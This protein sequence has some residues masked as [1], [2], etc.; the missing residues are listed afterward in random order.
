MWKKFC[1]RSSAAGEITNE[2]YTSSNGSTIRNEKTG[3]KNLLTTF[4]WAVW[5]NSGSFT[6]ETQ[7]H[8]GTTGSPAL[9]EGMSIEGPDE[10]RAVVGV[11]GL[12]DFIPRL[13]CKKRPT[14]RAL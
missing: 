3:Q 5:K 6:N 13:S 14:R 7:T 10:A 11:T 9:K 2:S 4:R 8:R 12:E 1:P